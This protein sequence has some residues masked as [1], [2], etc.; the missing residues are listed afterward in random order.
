MK[1]KCEVEGCDRHSRAKGLCSKHY[2]RLKRGGD[3]HT[4]SQKELSV[5]ERFKA[6]LATQDPVTGCIAWTGSR[7]DG[8]GRISCG[9]KIVKTHRLAW[10]L[11]H[12][13][14]PPGME[15]CHRCDNPPCCNEE[16]L[17][18]DTKAGNNADKMAKGRQ[19]KGAGTGTA[20]LTE[21]DVRE[22]RRRLALGETHRKIAS[23]FGVDHKTVGYISRGKTW[24]HLK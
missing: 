1:N 18:L 13:P 9:G 5:E 4:P 21:A 8:Y 2:L 7:S 14:I 12:G 6:G 10:E 15:V 23:Y 3:P 11:K 20:K 19:S 22:I 24:K 16:H 17:F